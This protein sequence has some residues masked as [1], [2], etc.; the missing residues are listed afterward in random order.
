MEEQI[1]QRIAQLETAERDT[2]TQ[3]QAICTVLAEMRALL[4]PPEEP[5]MTG[6]PLG[7]EVA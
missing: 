3:L 7:E 6:T 5:T 1:R 4:S 2:R